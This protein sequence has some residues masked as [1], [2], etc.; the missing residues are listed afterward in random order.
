METMRASVTAD[1]A[2]ATTESA[3]E[4]LQAIR[5]RLPGQLRRQRIESARACFGPLYTEAEV[6]RN[7]AHTLPFRLGSW[8][9]TVLEPIESYREVIPEE[10]LLKYDDAYRSGLFSRFWVASVAYR[11]DRRPD[12]WIL[13]EV[14]GADLF[15]VLAQWE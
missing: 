12:P 10:A 5:A 8:R 3:A 9:E 2:A 14:E 7:A 11:D 15:A 4:R 6:R 13:G 1:Q